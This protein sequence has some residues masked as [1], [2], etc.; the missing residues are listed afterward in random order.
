[1]I[2]EQSLLNSKEEWNSQWKKWFARYSKGNPR[3]GKWLV[4]KYPILESK[5]LEI[6]AGSGR[7]SLYL[8]SFAKSVTCVDFAPEAVSLLKN[9][10]LP[11][12]VSALQ[13]DASN[14]PFP[15]LNFDLT[16]HKGVW[17]LFSDNLRIQDFLREQLRVTN[18]IALA[19]VQNS[20]NTRQVKE[21]KEKAKSDPLF[22]IR[23]F[24]PQELED[25]GETVI[26]E[27]GDKFRIRVLKYGNPNLSKRLA[28]LGR[29]GEIMSSKIYKYLP[30][31]C[32]ECAVLEIS[33]K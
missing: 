14:L 4:E 21:A 23:F 24:D 25:I 33:R 28:W 7:E 1:M 9:S 19:I 12:N 11:E 16:F 31:S 20:L 3:L 5:T 6:G 17:V 13:A 22:N 18:K 8:A 32:I 10:G 2:M 15:D 27:L 26:R 29:F 30:W